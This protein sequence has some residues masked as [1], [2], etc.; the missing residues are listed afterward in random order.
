[1]NTNYQL[2][3]I[4]RGVLA[5]SSGGI[6]GLVDNLLAVCRDHA[7]QLEWQPSCFRFR[8]VG[9][10]WEELTD[11]SLRKSVFRAILARLA[12]LC[13]EQTPDAVS[14]YG[15]QCEL[16]LDANLP[17]LICVTFTNTPAEQRLELTSVAG[18]IKSDG[19]RQ[20]PSASLGTKG[21]H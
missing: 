16:S 5:Q 12:S 10:D 14:P 20:H 6:V 15:G 3:E 1:M 9:G 4:L 18:L 13:N 11:I 2:T 8:S 21:P 19:A 17:A 7:L